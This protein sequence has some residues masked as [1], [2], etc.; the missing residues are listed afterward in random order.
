MRRSDSNQRLKKTVVV[1]FAT[2]LDLSFVIATSRE[3]ATEESAAMYCITTPIAKKSAGRDR[4]CGPVPLK[5]HH[6]KNRS[7]A[8]NESTVV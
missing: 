1:Q 8:S 4:A 3:A 2:S 6:H 5:L 7:L